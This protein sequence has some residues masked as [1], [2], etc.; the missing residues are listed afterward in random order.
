M[1]NVIILQAL[2]MGI[3]WGIMSGQAKEADKLATPQVHTLKFGGERRRYVVYVPRSLDKSKP[4]MLVLVLH[5]GGG[6][7][8]AME[9]TLTRRGFDQWAERDG[10]IVVYPQ[11]IDRQWND[12]RGEAVGNSEVDD[13]GFFRALVEKLEQEFNIDRKRIF[14]TGISNGGIMSL[15]LGSELAD[16][17]A[18][19][20]P[21]TANMPVN[22]YN[23]AKPVQPVSMLL[24]NGTAD[25]LVPY[26]GGN[27]TG[28]LGRSD[29]G[30][31]V[32]TE[33]TVAFW[34]KHNHCAQEPK[35]VKQA[36]AENGTQVERLTYSKGKGNTEV[37]LYKIHNGGHTWPGG[38]QYLPERVVGKVCHELEA[39]E[40]IWQFFRTH[41]RGK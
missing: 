17:F 20:A 1:R 27:V 5:G 2:I 21:V 37:V 41:G 28:P 7:P 4:A 13:V 3:S 22:I 8:A 33:N 34:V 24:M 40:V 12:G 23:T 14:A 6:T 39:T 38:P 16:I 15:R 36:M 31:V 18:A 29:R 25:P 26:A 10:A 11:G 9:Q 32:S 19:I 35:V 30:K